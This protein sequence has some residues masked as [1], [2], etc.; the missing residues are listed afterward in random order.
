MKKVLLHGLTAGIFAAIASI[1]YNYAYTKAMWVD[2]SSIINT[3]SI[4]GS[5]LFG[6]MLAALGYHFFSKLV[7]K[8]T[9][10]WFNIIFLVLS[11]ASF[12]GS[13]ATELPLEIES[14][15]L[16]PGLSVPMHLFPVLFWLATKPLFN[17]KEN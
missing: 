3:F 11:F 14:P 9:D 15:E 13:F 16:F 10:V 2:F 5:T 17:Q 12:A 7:K 1:V 4:I 8:G 6:T